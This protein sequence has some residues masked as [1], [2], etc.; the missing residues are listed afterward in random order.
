M[1]NWKAGFN[2]GPGSSGAGA[3]RG[4]QGAART[5]LPEDHLEGLTATV[6]HD[7]GL[8]AF[9]FAVANTA[10]SL[11]LLTFLVDEARFPPAVAGT[12]LRVARGKRCRWAPSSRVPRRNDR[13][14]PRLCRGERFFSPGG[15]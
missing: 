4:R 14:R 11:F 1:P 8:R 13:R 5:L 2:H 6:R 3:A 10:M 9:A 15:A 12:V 7:D